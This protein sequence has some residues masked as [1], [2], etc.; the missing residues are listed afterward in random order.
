MPDLVVRRAEEDDLEAVIGVLD[1]AA[2]RLRAAGV[3]Q[4]PD[5]FE[6][7]SIRPAILAGETWLGF[8]DDRPVATVT[9]D[10]QD[11]IWPDDGEAGYCHRLASV[12]GVAGAGSALFDWAE[13]HVRAHDRSMMRLDCVAANRRLRRYYEDRGYRHQG[14]ATVG[15]G[16]GERAAD[17]TFQTVVSKYQRQLATTPSA[18]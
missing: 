13:D 5:R 7:E 9:I 1:D 8:L 12:S 4:W 6:A 2:A 11:P 18:I 14:D 3:D 16:P 15:G 17:S 10:W